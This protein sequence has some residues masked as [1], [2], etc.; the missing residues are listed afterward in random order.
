[1]KKKI[2]GMQLQLWNLRE[3]VMKLFLIKL[4]K[5]GK[6]YNNITMKINI[7]N[8]LILIDVYCYCYDYTVN[9]AFNTIASI[10]INENTIKTKMLN[11][12]TS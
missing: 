3:L 6:V 7:D 2:N 4:V 12:I 11:M 1:M 8:S 9:K 5:C 10:E